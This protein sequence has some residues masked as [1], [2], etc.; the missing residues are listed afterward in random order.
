MYLNEIT[1][2]TVSCTAHWRITLDVF[3]Y[4]KPNEIDATMTIEE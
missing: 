4:D 3:K 2:D 1:A